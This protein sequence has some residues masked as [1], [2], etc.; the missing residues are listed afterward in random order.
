MT[1]PVSR[2]VPLLA[3]LRRDRV[4]APET[5]PSESELTIFVGDCVG[6]ASKRIVSGFEDGL[7]GPSNFWPLCDT[8]VRGKGA[9]L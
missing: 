7:T 5:S 9:P 1:S 4:E 3:W 6:E 8:E 2:T